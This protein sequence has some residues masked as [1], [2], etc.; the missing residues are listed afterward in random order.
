MDKRFLTVSWKA[1][2]WNQSILKEINTEYSLKGLI[3]KLRLQYFGYLMQRA[4]LLEKT[5]M[6]EKT[7]GRRT[8]GWQRM[9]WLDGSINSMDVSLSNSRTW[10]W[11]GKPG[12]MW[13]MVSQSLTQ[14]SN[15][16]PT[17]DKKI[18]P[19]R[20]ATK[21]E[22]EKKQTRKPPTNPITYLKMS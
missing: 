8:R 16:T 22:G 7:E 3:L 18:I 2:R 15:W 10:W 1:R 9:S 11:T 5:V 6:L 19:E 13:A 17:M 20:C 4:D 21:Q 14:Q 12:V